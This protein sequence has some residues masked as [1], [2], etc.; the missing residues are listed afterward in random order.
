MLRRRGY[1][2]SL[3]MN[4]EQA[5]MLAK[6]DSPD[7]ILLD[8]NMPVMNG[9][10]ACAQLQDSPGLRMIP[11][12]FLTARQDSKDVVRG[13][14]VGGVDYVGKPYQS[15][16]LLK[17]IE[18][19]LSIARMRK[20]LEDRAATIDRHFREQEAFVRHELHNSVAPLVWMSESLKTNPPEDKDERNRLIDRVHRGAKQLQDLLG[21][22]GELQQI[23]NGSA[24]LVLKE[25]SVETLIREEI[26]QLRSST[27]KS[28]IFEIRVQTESDLIQ[29]DLGLLPGVFRNLLKNAYEHVADLHPSQRHLSVAIGDAKDGLKIAIANGGPPIPEEA[30]VRFFDK[31]NSTKKG[32][33]G[34]G[35]GTSY[36]K[37]VIESHGGHINVHSTEPEGTIV[38]IWLPRNMQMD[39]SGTV[40]AD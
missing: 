21:A 29:A 25:V 20:T 35:L 19:H 27:D 14:E 30:L 26:Q 36:A 39:S 15:I 8:V 33:G 2:L 28:L 32:S 4:G 17:R 18:T 23:S 3:A 12:I 24:S 9:F 5:L 10:D 11:V 1:K 22:I 34:T 16:E 7:L 40:G 13:F 38:R 6:R 37:I 31:F